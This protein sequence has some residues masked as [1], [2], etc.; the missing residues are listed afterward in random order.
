MTTHEIKGFLLQSTR[1]S[2]TKWRL[3]LFSQEK[4]RLTAWMSTG[5]KTKYLFLE[6][7]VPLW[8]VIQTRGPW[9][10]V[11]HIEIDTVPTGLIGNALFCG[12]YLNELILYLLGEQDLDPAIF[13]AYVKALDVL[14]SRPN[15]ETLEIALRQFEWG[16]LQSL[17]Y[18]ISLTI[19]A[20]TLNPIDAEK[21]YQCIPGEGLIEA[22]EGIAG[23][24]CLALSRG[25]WASPTLL[26]GA[27]QLMRV[28]IDHLLDGRVLK[29]R[30]L[31]RS[32]YA[33]Q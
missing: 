12:W 31:Y 27:K 22:R 23:I 19:E 21:Y 24:T 4:G 26:K 3:A 5:S 29:T 32:R 10:Q 17:G 20:R 25:E 8:F 1:L 30:A 15:Q 14:R 9:M 33:V 13:D 28:L 6:P 2:S 18:A 16:L 11:T 7:F